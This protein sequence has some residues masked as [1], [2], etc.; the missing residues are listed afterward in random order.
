MVELSTVTESV[1]AL[2]EAGFTA[3]LSLVDGAV[4]CDSC[5]T[6]H[7]AAGVVVHRVQRFEGSSDPDDLAIVQLLRDR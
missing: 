7:A 4:R 5:D 1:G 6:R 2:R 3:D